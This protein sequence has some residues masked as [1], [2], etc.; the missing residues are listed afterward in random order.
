MALL[1]ALSGKHLPQHLPIGTLSGVIGRPLEIETGDG[2]MGRGQGALW[3][4]GTQLSSVRADLD[5]S[6]VCEEQ[7]LR[8]HTS[9]DPLL[10]VQRVG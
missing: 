8:R 10:Q 6:Q 5:G 4:L 3:Q 7:A 2:W 1:G 9:A